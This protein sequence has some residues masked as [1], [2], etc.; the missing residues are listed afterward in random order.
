M[1]LLRSHV[2]VEI[3]PEKFLLYSFTHNTFAVYDIASESKAIAACRL[4]GVEAETIKE[5]VFAKPPTH[6]FYLDTEGVLHAKNLRLIM[7]ES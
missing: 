6:F 7:N 1:K 5:I 3:G 4:E 2:Y